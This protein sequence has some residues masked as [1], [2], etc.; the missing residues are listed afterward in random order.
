MLNLS[1]INSHVETKARIRVFPYLGTVYI[2]IFSFLFGVIVMGKSRRKEV[3]YP[4]CGEETSKENE[5]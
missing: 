4:F 3:L 5:I 2:F 1:D